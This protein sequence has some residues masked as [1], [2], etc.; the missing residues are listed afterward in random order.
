MIDLGHLS[1]HNRLIHPI[2]S[3]ATFVKRSGLGREYF[4]GQPASSI[5]NSSLIILCTTARPSL[6]HFITQAL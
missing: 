5:I 6:I 3:P 1:G 2:H 4:E